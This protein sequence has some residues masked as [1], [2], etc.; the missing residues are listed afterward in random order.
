MKDNNYFPFERNRYYFGKLLSV[1]DFE[2]EQSYM[3]HKR[4][5]MNRLMFGDGVV[6][7]MQV[8]EVDEESISVEAGVALDAWGREIVM[9]Q[10]VLKR[11]AVLDGF[12][13][14]DME[15]ESSGVFYLCIEYQEGPSDPVHSIGAAANEEGK[16]LEYNRW[17]EGYRLYLTDAGPETYSGLVNDLY[18]E[19][20][21]VIREQGVCVR[22]LVPRWIGKNQE[23]VIR[24]LIDKNGG[25][26]P[27]AFQYELE[28]DGASTAG[29]H[30]LS[31]SF[32]E[33]EWKQADTYELTYKIQASANVMD[34]NIR[35]VSGSC[36]W[37]Q[38][39]YRKVYPIEAEW[40]FCV[41]AGKTEQ[42]VWDACYQTAME[43][44]L[45]P[46][47]QPCLYLAKI[48]VIQAGDAYVIDGIKNLPYKQ[49]IWNN[50]LLGAME[51]MALETPNGYVQSAV[52]Q[53]A[54]GHVKTGHVSGPQFASGLVE[55]PFGIGG[56]RG[57]VVYSQE[58]VHGLG[59]GIVHITAAAVAD[60][61]GGREMVYGVRDLFPEEKGHVNVEVAVKL[62]IDTGSFVIGLRCLDE[63][64]SGSVSVYWLAVR[65]KEDMGIQMQQVLQIRPGM[66][67]LTVRQSVCFEAWIGEEPQTDIHWEV[68]DQEGGMIDDKGK[69]TAP[70]KTG[71]YEIHA[72]S[73]DDFISDAVAYVIV[74][75][76]VG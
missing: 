24:V 64:R 39:E 2:R 42:A 36:L 21:I 32:R 23:A 37:E 20:K 58:I 66:P 50:R 27:L 4:Q 31:V 56:S 28:L 40:N 59:V 35:M 22:Q 63:I 68:R 60:K 14:Y 5:L 3:N 33:S 47:Q 62:N 61:Q 48:S 7:G 45:H 57:Q 17:K 8:L 67:R 55:I 70:N 49:Y 69:Y 46:I 26:E 75:D 25:T 73:E 71:I 51:R 38:G 54:L 53:K 41:I 16:H 13:E 18:E 10:P 15:E 34:G 44:L 12:D 1:E 52:G 11:L 29:D 30:K 74:S 6:C 65:E 72:Y 43:E 9:E 19:M 76:E